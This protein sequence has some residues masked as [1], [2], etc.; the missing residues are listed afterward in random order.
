MIVRLGRKKPPKK[1]KKESDLRGWKTIL[2][3][4]APALNKLVSLEKVAPS[5]RYDYLHRSHDSWKIHGAPIS[6]V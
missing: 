2:L 1:K 5:K 4:T 6:F 3:P